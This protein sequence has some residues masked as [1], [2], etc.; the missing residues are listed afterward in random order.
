MSKWESQQP[1]ETAPPAFNVAIVSPNTATVCLDRSS[2]GAAETH[3]RTAKWYM[4][5]KDAESDNTILRSGAVITGNVFHTIDVN[6]TGRIGAIP[7][8]DC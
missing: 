6:A 4:N 3:H 5:C 1:E 7:P 2:R 8:I